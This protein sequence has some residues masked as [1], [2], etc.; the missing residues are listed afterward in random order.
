MA[1]KRKINAESIVSEAERHL[2]IR[3][4]WN[5]GSAEKLTLFI[6]GF[7]Q[8]KHKQFAKGA[9]FL[10]L[11]IAFLGWLAFSGISALSLLTTLGPNKKMTTGLDKDGIPVT[12]QPDN[13][14]IILLWGVLAILII[15]A[16]VVLFIQ[17]YKSNK[18]LVYLTQTGQ[19]IPSNKEELASLLDSNLHKTLMAV[20]LL[21]VFLFTILPTLYMITM[22]FTNYNKEHAIAFS[23][24]GLTSFGQILSGNLA[25]TFFPVLI[26]TLIWAVLATATTF[27]G[28]V[29]LA[30]LI[31]SKG[32]KGKGMWRTIFVIVFAVPQFVTLLLMA[33]FLNTQGALNNLLMDWHIIS[34]PIKF[35]TTDSNAW[36]SRATV[37]VVNMWIGIPVSMLTSTA[38]IQNLPQDQIEA[39]RI[40][41]ANSFRIFKS[42]T[43]P[44]ILFVMTPALIQQFIGNINNFNVIYLLTGGWPMNANYNSA[45]EKSYA[46]QRLLSL[47]GRYA[48]LIFLAIVWLFPIVWIV[49][50]SFTK[51]STGFVDTIIPDNFTIDNYVSLLKNENGVFP[52]V[53]WLVNTLIVSVLSTIISTLIIIMMSYVLSRLKFAFRK[54]FLQIALVLG[55]FPGFMSMIA[56]Y[57]ILKSFNMLSIGG[58][59]M[60]YAGGAGLAFYIAKGFFDTIPPSIDEAAKIDGANKWQVFTNITLPLSKPIIVYTALMAFIAPWTD[61]IFSGIILGNNDSKSFTIAYGLYT[62]VF[63]SKGSAT[64]YFTQF[65]AGCVII[66][67]PI[68]LLF[69]FMQK[70][71]VNGITAGADKG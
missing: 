38:I 15:A 27:L 41:G 34:E 58:L 39:A 19:H 46:H 42:I 44:Q 30:M 28:G 56:L 51:N 29:L 2:S 70:F 52:F 55:M 54:P 40:D 63:N 62:M 12:I 32:I 50:V 24:T 26:W 53:N 65:I 9:M 16:F 23:W 60:V 49:L 4:V 1:K 33:Q 36:V 68:T 6:M 37:I 22:A 5:A 10:L 20:P 35:I 31:E 25:G 57:Y 17:N 21:G 3:D 69:I 61:F 48:L 14:V 67:I 11:E 45:G 18:H 59:V 13:S 43:F 66:A 47:V 7:N 71:Y 64:T 8:L